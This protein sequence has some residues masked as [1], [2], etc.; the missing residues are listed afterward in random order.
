[1]DDRVSKTHDT[2]DAIAA[3]FLQNARDRSVMHGWLD[4]FASSLPAGTLVLD[5]GAGPGVDSAEL[6]KRG[7]EAISVDLSL[8][9]LRSG[10]GEF[11]GPRVQS[12]LR[13]LPFPSHSVWGVWASASLLH[14]SKAE[15]SLALREIRRVLRSSGIL[16]LSV[17]QG[18][19][20]EWESERYGR[21]R[22]FQYWSGPE[23][24]AA[25][26]AAGFCVDAAQVDETTRATWLIRLASVERAAQFGV[27]RRE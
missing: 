17:K 24:D 13:C 9:M 5:L 26:R 16:Y 14:L 2:Y 21:P 6:R 18:A 20:T 10:V 11:P 23:L 4:R 1:M 19:G 27:G 7:F 22:W 3:Q 12:D 25:L 8:G 15:A